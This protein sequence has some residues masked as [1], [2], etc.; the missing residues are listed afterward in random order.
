MNRTFKELT[1]Q[2]K[3]S[4]TGKRTRVNG[5]WVPINEDDYDVIVESL[6][7]GYATHK[8][9]IHKNGPRLSPDELVTICERGNYNF[10]HRWEGNILVV[11]T[12]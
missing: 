2:Y 9:R 3:I 1:E 5:E 8:Y 10:G 11:Y 4:F 7:S 6:G 12:D